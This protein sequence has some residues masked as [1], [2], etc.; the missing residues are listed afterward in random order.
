MDYQLLV[1]IFLS[2]NFEAGLLSFISCARLSYCEEE[3]STEYVCIWRSM[4]LVDQL[5]S[6][7]MVESVDFVLIALWLAVD[8]YLG[9]N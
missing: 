4:F 8:V 7:S 5:K 2:L 6:F 3:V 1:F 9:S